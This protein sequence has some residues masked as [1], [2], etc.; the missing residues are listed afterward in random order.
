MFCLVFYAAVGSQNE[1]I[2][3]TSLIPHICAMLIIYGNLNKIL[4]V[5]VCLVIGV[6]VRRIVLPP[7][8]F[9]KNIP[10]IPFYVCFVPIL[11]NWDQTKIFEKYYR[12]KME[13]YGAVKIYFASRWNILVSKPE[14]V[15]E[16][17]RQNDIFEKS[18]NQEKIPYAVIS[19]Y[20]GDN[21]ISA[22]NENWAKY[23]SVAEDSI[24]FPDLEPLDANVDSLVKSIKLN[25]GTEKSVRVNDIFQSF[26]LAC[27]GDCVIGCNLKD[28]MDGTSVHDKIIFLKKQIFQ[29][30]YM[31]FTF[32]DKFPIPSRVKARKAV[33][34]F[35]NFYVKKI[36][37]E[38]SNENTRRLGPRL[39]AA[40]EDGLITE[41]QFQD[42]AMITM[43]AGHENPQILLTTVTYLISKHQSVQNKLRAELRKHEENPE[44]CPYLNAV[45]YESL[46]MYP[47]L[48]QL[49]NRISRK[50]VRLGKD[51]IIPKGV[52]I[53]NN[54][55]FTQRDRNCWVDADEFRPDRWGETGSQIASNYRKAK[56]NC[57]LTAFH[58]RKRA[59]LGQLF[60]LYEVKR[61]IIRLVQEFQ[62]EVDPNWVERWTSSGP[63]WPVNLSLCF[64]QLTITLDSTITR[65]SLGSSSIS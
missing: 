10:T 59:C 64:K 51:I 47:P 15:S 60:A 5:V 29:P 43:I 39:A 4:S 1:G 34:D 50:T 16:I 37:K 30:L 55:F 27:I 3:L 23:R 8:T 62:I 13:K 40:H 20:L 17:I 36:L 42:N 53:G 2:L 31:N 56:S 6:W 22:G 9:P 26:A 41:K 24:K 32:L 21:L 28:T 11:T 12:N 65:P 19:E 38:R 25:I 35:K 7:S 54:S 44:S 63:M 52:Y 58:G 14:Y 18:G 33:R 57:T 61:A 48:A 49:I 45:V 46:R